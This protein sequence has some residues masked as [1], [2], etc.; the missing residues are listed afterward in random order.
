LDNVVTLVNRKA[1]RGDSGIYKLILKNSEGASQIQFR[2]NV[3][4]PPSKPEGP[5]EATNVTAEGCT[6][7]WKPPVRISIIQM[8]F[9]LNLYL[10]DVLER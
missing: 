10:R 5:L 8:L 6:L 3:L 4:S 1:E 2:V 7:N 9:F